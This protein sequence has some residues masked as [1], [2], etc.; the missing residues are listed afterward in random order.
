MFKPAIKRDAKL[1][2]ALTGPAGSGKTFTALRLATAL[3]G[4][5]KVAYVDTEHGSASKY[6][7]T[8]ICSAKGPCQDESHFTFDTDEP[9]SFDPRELVKAIDYASAE[10]YGAIVVDSLSH[11]WMGTG[12]ELELVDHAAKNTRSGNS[13]AAWKTVTPYHTALVDKILSAQIHVIV[14]MRSKT[15]WV[16]EKDEKT[17]KTVPRKIGLQPVMRDGIEFEFDVAGELDQ[18]NTLTMSKSRCSALQGKSIHRPGKGM[19]DILREWLAGAPAEVATSSPSATAPAEQP[20]NTSGEQGGSLRSAPVPPTAAAGSA[21]KYAPPRTTVNGKINE[22]PGLAGFNAPPADKPVSAPR[23]FTTEQERIPEPLVVPEE[24]RG[25]FAKM[26][27]AAGI[28]EAKGLIVGYCTGVYGEEATTADLQRLS[29][30]HGVSGNGKRALI[31]VKKCLLEL[32]QV[33]QYM[34]KRAERAAQTDHPQFQASDEDL[35]PI[36]QGAA[37]EQGSLIETKKDTNYAD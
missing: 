19:A 33:G 12:G 7:H 3:A 10:G 18:E 36:L 1:R 34:E 28:A 21:P 37:P 27:S 6:A 9:S 4:S 32:W 15:E 5:R 29:T 22:D 16:T 31:D 17:G 35:P 26:T 30:K 11:Y 13:F 20:S 8:D 24:L 23:S 2:L 25:I 14:T